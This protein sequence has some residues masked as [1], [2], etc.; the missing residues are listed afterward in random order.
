M[1]EI[2]RFL[3]CEPDKKNVCNETRWM[4]KLKLHLIKQG[5]EKDALRVSELHQKLKGMV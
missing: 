2:N 5:R 4:E 3:Q 1:G